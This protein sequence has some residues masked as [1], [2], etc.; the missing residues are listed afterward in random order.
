[1]TN[2]HIHSHRDLTFTITRSKAEDDHWHGYALFDFGWMVEQIAGWPA[3]CPRQA[4]LNA[5]HAGRR[6]AEAAVAL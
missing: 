3:Q 4:Y 2:P 5:L 1:M 6:Y